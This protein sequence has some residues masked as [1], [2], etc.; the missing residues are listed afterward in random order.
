MSKGASGCG[1]RKGAVVELQRRSEWLAETIAKATAEGAAPSSVAAK[2]S[3][4]AAVEA[5]IEALSPALPAEPPVP[6]P[7]PAEADEW[8]QAVGWTPGRQAV[9]LDAAL[10]RLAA[11]AGPEVV[12]EALRHAHAATRGA[13]VA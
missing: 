9:F 3:E 8:R 13:A 1:R 2:R 4:R 10:R 7:T 12:A 11:T 6:S 5:A